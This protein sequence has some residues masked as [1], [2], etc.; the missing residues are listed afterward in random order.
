MK[1]QSFLQ[2]ALLL[3]LAGLINRIIGFAL[4]ILI[5]QTIGDEGLGLFQRVF[6][7]FMTLLLISTAGFPLAISKMIP[8]KLAKNNIRGAFSLLKISLVFILC[9]STTVVLVSSF[10]VNF[11]S[12]KLYNDSRLNLVLLAILPAVIISALASCFKGFFQGMQTMMPTS[13]SQITEQVCRFLATIVILRIISY[14]GIHYRSAGIA[15]GIS[16]GEFCGFLLLIV[17]FLNNLSSNLNYNSKGLKKE[18]TS[19]CKYSYRSDLKEIAG[20]AVPIT[21]G[22]I[23]NSLMIS[24]EAILIPRKLVSRGL[25]MTEATS[26]YGQLSGMVEQVIFLPTV[27][28]I[29][30]TTSLIP[31]I[32]AAKARNDQKKIRNNYQETIRISC[33]LGFPITVIFYRLGTNICNLLFGYPQAGNLLAVM[34]FSSTFIYYLQVSQGMLNGLG[35]PHLGV[36]NMGIGSLIK[37]LGIFF[38]TDRFP[39]IFGAAVSICL[40][41]CLSALLNYIVIGNHIG[42]MINIKNTYLK[43]LI[44]SIILYYSIGIVEKIVNPYTLHKKF[45]TLLILIIITAIYLLL[46]ILFRAITKEDLKYFK[47]KN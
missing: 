34:A 7:F 13:L 43:P 5:V 41:V 46:M 15:L 26:L 22:R 16:I 31:T 14:P 17:I 25:S 42:Y 6:P 37:L 44:S 27:I 28:T 24:A 4:R 38:L 1:K 33:Y 32:S 21:I 47:H 40:G 45:E 8:E 30:L 12:T 29:A 35:K 10:S 11:I 3:M 23:I 9:I 2:G 18:Y 39:G 19:Q 36:I 20:L